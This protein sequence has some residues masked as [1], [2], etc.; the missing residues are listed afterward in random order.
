MPPD[1]ATAPTSITPVILAGGRGK[2]LRPLTSRNRPKPFL[3]LF[4]KRSL[5][6]ET[7][8]R[9]KEFRDPVILSETHNLRRIQKHLR[10]IKSSASL[11]LEEKSQGTAIA[12]LL[13]A[14][15][16]EN[17]E[18]AMLV[19]PSDHHIKPGKESFANHI[20]RAAKHLNDTPTILFGVPPTA[21]ETRYGYI[22]CKNGNAPIKE[23]EK[24]IEKPEA[25][26]A[27]SLLKKGNCLWNTGILL[28]R[29][30]ALLSLAAEKDPALYDH[31]QKLFHQG[32]NKNTAHIIPSNKQEKTYGISIDYAIL[33]K[34][35]S[36]SVSPLPMSWYDIGCWE[37][38]L[39]LKIG[40]LFKSP[41]NQ[42]HDRSTEILL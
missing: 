37:S 41:S 35:E 24:F 34:C 38:L 4:S 10:E 39:D 13:A 15:K 16:L 23:I 20:N 40:R 2:R 22:V 8:L 31:A 9:V 27:A 29:P 6:Q 36:L 32:Y 25:G 3:R 30:T 17:S 28:I 33:E 5:L 26:K 1:H 7:I 11:I 19:L 42:S 12:L 14:I 18:T 21:P